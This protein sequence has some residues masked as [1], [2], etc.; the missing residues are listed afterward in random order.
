M[1]YEFACDECMVTWEV[2]RP[3]ERAG[4]PEPCPHCDGP[5]RR[6]YYAPRLMNRAKPRSFADKEK[7][8]WNG[9]D[10]RLAALREAESQGPQAV[11][12]AR[13]NFGR[14][15]NQVLAYKKE[16]YA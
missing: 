13:K 2:Q 12:E 6:V 15:F 7:T 5:T 1:I 3:M 11:R 4:D 10:S 8:T 16:N 14:T 9:W